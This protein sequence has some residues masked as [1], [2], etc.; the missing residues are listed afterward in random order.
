M[1][2]FKQKVFGNMQEDKDGT[3]VL[4]TEVLEMM[5]QSIQ[6]AIDHKDEIFNSVGDFGK[7]RPLLELAVGK[8][9]VKLTFLKDI[10]GVVTRKTGDTIVYEPYNKKFQSKTESERVDAGMFVH[11]YGHGE[12]EVLKEGVNVSV[13]YDIH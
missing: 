6:Y 12:F 5:Q 13:S 9:K 7:L 10:D 8:P 4:H 3:L 11:C 2:R 1:K